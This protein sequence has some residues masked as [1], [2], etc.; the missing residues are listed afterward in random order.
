MRFVAV[1]IETANADCTSICQIGVA[2]FG[3]DGVD[4]TW[5]SLIDPKDYFDSMNVSIHGITADTVAGSPTIADVF[6][7]LRDFLEDEFVVHHMPFDRTSLRRA[8][9]MHSVPAVQAHWIDTARVVRRTWPARASSGYGL[10]DVARE[11]GISFRHHDALEDAVACGKVFLAAVAESGVPV[12]E[13]VVRAHQ[14][15]GGETYS[16]SV[17]R[18][19]GDAGPL[20]GESLVFTGSLSVP[21]RDAANMAARAGAAVSNSVTRKTRILVVGVQDLRRT[22]E[23]GKSS[24]HQKAESLVRD[25]F[26]IVIVSEEDFV[27]M[28]QANETTIPAN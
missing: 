5:S 25:G 9:E 20:A 24:K 21:R 14:P 27:S 1:D 3:R 16:E 11:L 26:D 10:K 12:D 13:W 19:G 2:V 23:S 8:A 22:G 15:I 6:P 28:C 4:E 17:T 7:R 18:A